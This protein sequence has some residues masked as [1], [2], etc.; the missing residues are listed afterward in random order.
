MAR[1]G[2]TQPGSHDAEADAADSFKRV[3]VLGKVKDIL[4]LFTI[5]EPE[6]D[7]KRIRLGSG[8]PTST[9]VRLVRNMVS[10]GLLAQIGTRYRIGI[11]VLRWAAVALQGLNLVE[12]ANPI[13][14]SLRDAT[15]ESSGLF[16][17][18]GHQRVCIALSESR[19]AVGRRLILGNVLPIHVGAPGKTL[20]A[21]DAA[22][23]EILDSIRLNALTDQ[24]Y[25]D[26]RSLARELTRIR[27]DGF[28][29]SH[30]EWDIEVAGVA[31]PIFGADGNLLAAIGISGPVNRLPKDV[32]P[33]IIRAV[34]KAATEMST[35]Y[36]SSSRTR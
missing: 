17:R 34:S 11:S 29:V 23:D 15:G 30:G 13:L 12:I 26:R 25:T 4:D 28:A 6:L 31:A 24:T 33:D 21:F 8:L 22:R 19:R 2:T 18:D 1:R 5:E 20:L 36:G 3:L 32:L 10:D 9:C 35:A 16:V 7:L 27:Q 14:V